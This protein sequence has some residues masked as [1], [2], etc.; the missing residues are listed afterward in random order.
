MPRKKK[1][2][3]SKRHEMID[4]KTE[5]ILSTSGVVPSVGL[6]KDGIFSKKWVY[7]VLGIVLIA[8]GYLFFNKGLLVVA[9]VNGKPIFRWDLN[10]VVM[11]RFGSQTLESMI[12]EALVDDVAK[13][14]GVTVTQADITAKENEIVG[15]L[16]SN[17]KIDDL[18]KYQGMTKADFESQ[19]RLQLSVEKILGKS[20]TITD[21]DVEDFIA[22]NEATF[23]ATDEA[24]MRS[25]AREALFSQKISEKL[26]PW[27]TQLKQKATISRFLQ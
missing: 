9:V 3:A 18:L 8:G 26:Q 10:R 23:T 24:G 17:V 15:S 6:P 16:G 22:K 4:T 13:K 1:T 21:G 11:S 25:Q 5:D 19:I 20:I 14:E 27:F 12:S 2:V 7:I